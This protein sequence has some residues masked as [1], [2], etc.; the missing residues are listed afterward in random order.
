MRDSILGKDKIKFSCVISGFHREVDENCTVLGY[1]G[2]SSGNLVTTG[3]LPL[4]AA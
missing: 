4:H 2:A 3:K 1:Y